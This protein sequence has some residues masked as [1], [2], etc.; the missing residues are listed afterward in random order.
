M[1]TRLHDGR[2]SLPKPLTDRDGRMPSTQP[3]AG[4]IPVNTTHAH[5][6]G[7]AG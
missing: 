6:L 2:G 7:N 5:E 3:Q 1:M 4:E